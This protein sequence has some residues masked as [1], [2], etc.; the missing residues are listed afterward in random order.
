MHFRQFSAPQTVQYITKVTQSKVYDG[1]SFYRSDFVIQ[2]GTHGTSKAN[3][4]GPLTINE[5]H[6]HAKVSNTRGTMAVAHF[7]VPDCGGSEIFINL[8]DNVHLDGAYGG[9]CVFA[10]VKNEASFRVV[11]AIAAA[12]KQKGSVGIRQ[13]VIQ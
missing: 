4:H 10:R 12:V 5:T 11:D 1:T 6:D 2:M 3:P 9:F 7:D 8:N 13:A